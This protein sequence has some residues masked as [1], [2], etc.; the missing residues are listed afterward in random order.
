MYVT[1]GVHRQ[2][3]IR[4][5]DLACLSRPGHM[6]SMP[7]TVAFFASQ[8][9]TCFD[10]EKL[11]STWPVILARVENNLMSR[12]QQRETTWD[13]FELTTRS[14][15]VCFCDVSCTCWRGTVVEVE[16]SVHE[17]EDS[18]VERGTSTYVRV[19]SWVLT[20]TWWVETSDAPVNLSWQTPAGATSRWDALLLEERPEG[21]QSRLCCWTSVAQRVA[22]NWT[23]LCVEVTLLFVVSEL[24]FCAWPLWS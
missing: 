5:R 1:L 3:P 13:C 17:E 15:E 8:S 18:N 21:R 16:V 11:G 2:L 7:A 12:S 19:L 4:P 20:W 23:L 24:R 14:L 9:L 6:S 22:T 10:R